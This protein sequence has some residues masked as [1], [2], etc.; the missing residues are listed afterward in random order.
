LI[1]DFQ[2]HRWP[3]ADW[4]DFSDFAARLDSRQDFAVM[5]GGRKGPSIVFG[6]LHPDLGK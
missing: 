1:E 6:T 2:R 5:A 3:E 4:F